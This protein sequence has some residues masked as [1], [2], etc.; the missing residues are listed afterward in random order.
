M[1]LWTSIAASFLLSMLAKWL[2]DS[3]LTE[4]IAILGSFAGLRYTLNPNVAFSLDF[5]DFQGALIA[6]ALVAICIVA[7]RSAKTRL[8]QIGYGIIIGGALGNI[9]D[10]LRDG[11][12]TDFFQVGTFP[13][14]NVADS[15]ITVGVVVLLVET[16]FVAR[17]QK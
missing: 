8:S 13:V 14:F 11:A 9:V 3:F 12:V 7:F 10:R 15:W 4:R 5:G 1:I 2:A 6:G 17:K 16:L